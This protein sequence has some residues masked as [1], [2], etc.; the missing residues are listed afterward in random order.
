MLQHLRPYL[1]G[2]IYIG[3]T[4]LT[5]LAAMNNQNNLLFWIFGVLIAAA[6]ISITLA[7]FVLRCSHVRRLDPHYGAVGEPLL[8]RYAVTNRSRWMSIFNIHI[9]EQP[10][11]H[12][13][14]A[15]GER[16]GGW[17]RLM[18]PA[19]AWVMHAGPGEMVHGEAMFWPLARG[20]AAFDRV[21]VHTNFPFGVIR[22]SRVISQPQHTLIYPMLY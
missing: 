7:T 16:S 17:H 18:R 15:G 2:L 19:S 9:G 14:K 12:A 11:H 8:I 21:C 22:R 4:V 20:E 1:P 13:S 6:I 3:L 10:L 5:G